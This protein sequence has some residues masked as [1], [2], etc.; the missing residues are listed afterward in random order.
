MFSR[1][2][3]SELGD[4]P[5]AAESWWEEVEKGYTSLAGRRDSRLKIDEKLNNLAEWQMR[6]IA[7]LQEGKARR[8]V[9]DTPVAALGKSWE[10]LDVVVPIPPPTERKQDSSR[11]STGT[12]S[13][14]RSPSPERK[15]KSP[16]PLQS[17]EEDPMAA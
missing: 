13:P 9:D 15:P 8:P 1:R 6:T 17:I 14:S 5:A 11:S 3:S 4:G 7:F 10:E 2:R 12:G 16:P